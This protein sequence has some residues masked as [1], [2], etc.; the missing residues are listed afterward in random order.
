MSANGN[1]ILLLNRKERV[2]VQDKVVRL[3][4]RVTEAANNELLQYGD[5]L[6]YLHGG[7]G[8]AFPKVE[9]ALEGCRVGDQAELRLSPDEG[10][11]DY[12]P[13]RVL[14]MACAGFDE[15]RPAL[16]ESV[17][18]EL[19]DGTS[20]Y[21]SVVDVTDHQITLDGNHPF[22]GKQLH[23]QFEVLEIRDSTDAERSAGFA[24]DALFA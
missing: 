6:V 23:F 1:N 4:F 18:A 2:V 3:R 11:G 9:R 12:D 10:Y 20:M 7:Y 15:H 5:D 21:F 16:G 24:F 17:E 22:A 13:A 14:V 8:G 19:A